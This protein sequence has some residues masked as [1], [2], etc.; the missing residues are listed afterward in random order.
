VKVITATEASR[1]FKE[2][3]DRVEH[4]ETVVVTRGGRHVA[5]LGPA[6]SCP[7]RVVKNLLR[8]H[9]V[10]PEYAAD[11]AIGR[12]SVRLDDSEWDS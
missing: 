3:L 5:V 11:T 4:G 10:D 12:A 1:H 2:L 8:A 9:A 6:P 7:G